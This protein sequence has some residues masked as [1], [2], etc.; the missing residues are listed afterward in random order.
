MNKK[1]PGSSSSSGM[2][3]GSL[4]RGHGEGFWE[5]FFSLS[6]EDIFILPFSFFFADGGGGRVGASTG[7][8]LSM[9]RM[10]PV[11]VP[12][13]PTSPSPLHVRAACQS[14]ACVDRR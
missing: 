11:P 13:T 6:A 12:N 10:V 4:G 5:S 3:M 1:H 9:P 7:D 2:T 8:P 14:A